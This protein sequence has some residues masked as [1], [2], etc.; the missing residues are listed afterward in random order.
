MSAIGLWTRDELRKFIAMAEETYEKAQ[1]L[2]K[3][4]GKKLYEGLMA[5]MSFKGAS[6]AAVKYLD[7]Q[8]ATGMPIAVLDKNNLWFINTDFLE[9]ILRFIEPG[10][11]YTAIVRETQPDPNKYLGRVRLYLPGAWGEIAAFYILNHPTPRMKIILYIFHLATHVKTFL[12]ATIAEVYTGSEEFLKLIDGIDTKQGAIE[13]MTRLMRRRYIPEDMYAKSLDAI[14]RR[15][16]LP[17]SNLR[18][19][20]EDEEARLYIAEALLEGVQGVLMKIHK[21]IEE[22]GGK[23]VPREK[24]SALVGEL[25]SILH[26]LERME[27]DYRKIL[28][29][30]NIVLNRSGR[31][32]NPEKLRKILEEIT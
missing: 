18:D 26:G 19:V 2:S 22:S 8:Y 6:E 21:M 1:V 3:E 31:E 11:D 12:T 29:K 24:V 14:E 7:M 30:L 10:S 25:Y 15:R 27:N 16:E 5:A 23:P 32:V 20:L 4:V 9:R 28:D 17:F 13:F